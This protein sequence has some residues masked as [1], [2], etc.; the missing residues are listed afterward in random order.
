MWRSLVLAL[1]LVPTV[2]M[3]ADFQ[4]PETALDLN[5]CTDPNDLATCT[6]VPNLQRQ[7]PTQN[8]LRIVDVQEGPYL[9]V[10]L[11][12]EAT[13]AADDDRFQAARDQL[14]VPPDPPDPAPNCPTD[15]SGSG[16]TSGGFVWYDGNP[17]IYLFGR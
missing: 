4:C 15:N 2:A 11:S 1:L 12:I 8:I 7:T 16:Q 5:T 14:C 10:R 9:G 6:P 13:S 17:G 3:A